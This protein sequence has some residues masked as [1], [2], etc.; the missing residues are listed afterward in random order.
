MKFRVAMCGLVG[1]FVSAC[2]VVYAFTRTV[3]ISPAEP[4]VWSLARW[5]QPVVLLSLTLHF[6]VR[7]YWVLVANALTYAILGTLTELLRRQLRQGN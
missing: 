3:P 4:L 7:F 5:T 6:G 2:W 1:F